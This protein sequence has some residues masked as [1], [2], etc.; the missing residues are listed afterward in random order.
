MIGPH[1]ARLARNLSMVTV[2]VAVVS[3]ALNDS[4]SIGFDWNAFSVAFDSRQS[5]LD[6]LTGK[7]DETTGSGTG[8]N[9]GGGAD[10]DDDDNDVGNGTDNPEIGRAHV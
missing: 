3:V 7:T 5:T 10:D 8:N 9:S 2:Q 4:S 6:K 1:L